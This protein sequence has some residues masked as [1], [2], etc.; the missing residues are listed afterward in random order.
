[1]KFITDLLAPKQKYADK[2]FEKKYR[3][4]YAYDL[5]AGSMIEGPVIQISVEEVANFLQQETPVELPSKKKSGKV[6]FR[7]HISSIAVHPRKELY[8]LLISSERIV[9]AVDGNGSPLEA[10]LLD[11]N[12]LPKPE[13]IAFLSDNVIAVSSEGDG[14]TPAIALFDISSKTPPPAP[15]SP[16]P[17]AR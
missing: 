8:Y 1:M 12:V 10:M 13:G 4:V 17:P 7:F 6:K 14:G 15:R 5:A 2:A 11:E 3:A 9:L 16:S